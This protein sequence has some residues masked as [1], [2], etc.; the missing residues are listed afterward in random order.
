MKNIIQFGSYQQEYDYKQPIEW[1]VLEKQNNKMLLVS[2]NILDCKPYHNTFS[3]TNWKNCDLRRWLNSTFMNEAFSKEEQGCILDSKVVNEYIF[4]VQDGYS[5]GFIFKKPKYI[6]KKKQ[7]SCIDKVFLLSIKEVYKYFKDEEERL[8][9]GSTYALKQ[10]LWTSKIKESNYWLRDSKDV[11]ASSLNSNCSGYVRSYGLVNELGRNVDELGCGIRPA[12]WVDLSLLENKVNEHDGIQEHYDDF[13]ES[14]EAI[15]EEV[16]V[17]QVEEIVVNHELD[18]E[19]I[20]KQAAALFMDEKFY[21]AYEL[22]YK[23]KGYKNAE[24]MLK[25]CMNQIIGG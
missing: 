9:K 19:A 12:L 3:E 14:N 6:E 16:K 22:F 4:K 8:A 21:E 11:D 18:Q 17:E 24:K 7:L 15:I 25:I 2:K 1:I 20:Y 23:I 13:K 10:G 5:G